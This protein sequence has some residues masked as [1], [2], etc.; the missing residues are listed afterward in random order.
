MI[1][2]T[3]TENENH[4]FT[5]KENLS[6]RLLD[7]S[8]WKTRKVSYICQMAIRRRLGLLWKF[9]SENTLSKKTSP[10]KELSISRINYPLVI[11]DMRAGN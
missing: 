6:D 11:E 10:N 2:I 1:V 9:M 3:R 4:L 5:R 7:F 8:W